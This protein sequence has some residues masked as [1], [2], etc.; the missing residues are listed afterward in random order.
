[1]SERELRRS[2]AVLPMG[3]VISLTGLTARQIRYY[4]KQELILP[5][6]SSSNHRLYSLNDVDRLL[7][8]KDYIDS[9]MT[10]ADIIELENKT[11]RSDELSDSEA[12]RLLQADLMRSGRL[13]GSSQTTHRTH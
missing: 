12:R 9:G 1:M 2:L 13:P 6:R 10:I 3:T 5:K 11:R 7:V 4:E 8:I